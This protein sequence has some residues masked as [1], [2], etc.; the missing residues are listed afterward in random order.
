MTSVPIALAASQ[1]AVEARPVVAA[2][3]ALDQMPAQ[4]V[5]DREDAELGEFAVIMRGEGVVMAGGD[6]VDALAV[7]RA[8]VRRA[9]EAALQE[10]AEQAGRAGQAAVGR[11]GLRRTALPTAARRRR[12]R[13]RCR[14]WRAG[15]CRGGSRSAGSSSSFAIA[16]ATAGGSSCG[17][18]R[19]LTPSSICCSEPLSRVAMTG[20]RAAP[21][22]AMTCG[23]PSPR[24]SQTKMSS[25]AS[26]SGT[27]S[28]SPRKVSA[29][30]RPS[31]CAR[32]RSATA[33][34]GMKASGPPIT[35][36]RA[37]GWRAWT[38]AAASM[39]SSTRFFGSSRPTQPISG[40][41]SAMPS[42]ARTGARRRGVEGA[43]VD[44][45]RDL[46][47]VVFAA[48][49]AAGG[50]IADRARRRRHSAR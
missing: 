3:L 17:T 1:L 49:H 42:A 47:R 6:D 7:V 34:S 4:A 30:S 38:S 19:P 25:A 24:D 37:R 32:L 14:P 43:H 35:T 15:R 11:T 12:R 45:R 50:G 9:F 40:T 31:A 41:S 44:H 26:R 13:T 48:G 23:M 27:S 28:R 20:R 18:N 29:V 10:A 36:K 33:Y 16:A 2:G 22:S 39:K 8:A 46:D 21:A 5:A